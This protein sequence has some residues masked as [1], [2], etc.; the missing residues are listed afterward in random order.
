[1]ITKKISC[2]LAKENVYTLKPQRKINLQLEANFE[3]YTLNAM[4]P[5]GAQMISNYR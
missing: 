5:L 1:M 3:R 2:R 4:C